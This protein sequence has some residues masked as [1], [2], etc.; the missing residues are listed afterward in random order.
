MNPRHRPL[1]APWD[2]QQRALCR[3]MDSSVFFSPHGERGAEKRAREKKARAVC[4]RCPVIQACAW[5]AMRGPEQY[6]VWGGMS[7]GQRTRLL[8]SR[9]RTGAAAEP[10]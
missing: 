7:E 10:E 9:S 4:R 3:G 1:L 6:G 5:T 8:Q 2:W